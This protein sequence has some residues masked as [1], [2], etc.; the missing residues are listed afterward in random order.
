MESFY[1]IRTNLKATF[2]CYSIDFTKFKN[3]VLL[4]I[5]V[6][7]YFYNALHDEKSLL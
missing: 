3:Y 5:I 7:F 6:T 1:V 4:G 2:D